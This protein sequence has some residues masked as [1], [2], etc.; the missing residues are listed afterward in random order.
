MA[1]R[2]GW[3]AEGAAVV[4]T[5]RLLE[6]LPGRRLAADVSHGSFGRHAV[7]RGVFPAAWYLVS[8]GAV[9]SSCCCRA[10]PSDSPSVQEWTENARRLHTM[11]TAK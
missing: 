7:Q 3:A 1:R 2:D 9:G 4:A 5:S 10:S 8:F 11:V 6:V